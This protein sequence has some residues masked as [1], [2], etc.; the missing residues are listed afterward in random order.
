MKPFPN[1][2]SHEPTVEIQ[3]FLGPCIDFIQPH[4]E[5]RNHLYVYPKYLNYE[6]QKSFSRARN[7]VCMIELR[8]TDTDECHPL[9]VIYAAP[10]QSSI[11]LT[12]ATT[13]VLH[14]NTFPE[15]NN[16]VK[17][18]LPH[19][20]TSTHHLLFTFCHIAIEA[21][22]AGKKEDPVETVGYSWLP[23]LSRGRI[24]ADDH[25]LPVAAHLPAK[26]LSIEPL[27]LGRGVSIFC[28]TIFNI[29]LHKF[30]YSFFSI[31]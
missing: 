1:P 28:F 13:T 16:E 14:H 12:T 19:N 18:V 21:A 23:L 22:K 10:G 6:N 17:V 8:D 3:E 9:R 25:T 15:W 4:I 11:L 5:F 31:Q 29:F 26:Y 2:P 24:V 20:L 30:S 27:G 7:L